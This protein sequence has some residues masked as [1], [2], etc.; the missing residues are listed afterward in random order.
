MV[1][2]TLTSILKKSLFLAML[3]LMKWYSCL[4]PWLL[5]SHPHMNLLTIWTS[6][7]LPLPFSINNLHTY[8]PH[9]MPTTLRRPQH[10][11]PHWQPISL[12]PPLYCWHSLSSATPLSL[13]DQPPLMNWPHLRMYIF[14]I[15]SLGLVLELS[16]QFTNS[17][18]MLMPPPLFPVITYKLLKIQSG[19]M[20]WRMNF[21]RLTLIKRGSVPQHAGANIVNCIWLLKKK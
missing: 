20:L 5:T 7:L 21:L 10:Q 1:Y 19:L 4:D 13:S 2:A 9:L 12:P 6:L 16:N 8:N 18:F 11:L 17:I 14:T 15:W 3:L